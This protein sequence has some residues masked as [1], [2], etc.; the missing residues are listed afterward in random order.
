M[1]DVQYAEFRDDP[2]ATITRLY[3][4]LGR[5]LSDEA[6]KRMRVFLAG[7]PGDGGGNR[8][9]FADTGLD[10]DAL[11]RPLPALPGAF[12][13]GVRAGALTAPLGPVT[14]PPNG[15]GPAARNR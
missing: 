15:P 6:E 4:A 1:V 10:A 8:Y 7:N 3:G 2:L 9:T 11:A 14:R 13:G 12:R 5:D